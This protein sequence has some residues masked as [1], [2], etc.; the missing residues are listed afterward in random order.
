MVPKVLLF[1]SGLYLLFSAV[2]PVLVLLNNFNI[3]LAST[4]NT[5][6]LYIKLIGPSR[7]RSVAMFVIE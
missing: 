2:S 1:V 4:L 6:S 7:I 3:I 5:Y